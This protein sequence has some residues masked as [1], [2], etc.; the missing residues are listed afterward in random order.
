MLETRLEPSFRVRVDEQQE[1]S[2]VAEIRHPLVR[3]C[4]RVMGFSGGHQE[5]LTLSQVPGNSGLGSSGAFCCAL[6]SVLATASGRTVHQEALAELA[7]EVEMGR[8]GRCVGKQDPYV[9]AFGGLNA[10]HVAPD[11]RVK[12]EPLRLSEQAR[13]DLND[14]VVLSFIGARQRS[15]GDV[16]Q[17]QSDALT[18]CSEAHTQAMDW[19]KRIGLSSK[20]VLEAG[21]VDAFGELMDEHWRWKKSLHAA[22][23]MPRIDDCYARVREAG[24]IGGKIVGAGG[25]GFL[26]LCVRRGRRQDVIDVVSRFGMIPLSVQLG[27]EGTSTRALG[28]DG[29]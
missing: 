18:R 17:H 2:D 19:I 6:L 14:S 23:T 29:H 13:R 27:V 22:M 24:A 12:V 25:S 7:C 10:Y 1:L 21:D 3:E 26:L 15:A 20:Q 8:L 28:T 9:S 4:C 11:G 5:L 16:L